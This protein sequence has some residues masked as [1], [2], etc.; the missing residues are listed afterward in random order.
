M[1]D[2]DE[3]AGQE[4]VK[5]VGTFGDEALFA[6]SDSD[7]GMPEVIQA[8]VDQATAHQSQLDAAGIGG[9]FALLAE[10]LRD[11][12]AQVIT[13]DHSG[14][15]FGVNAQI[16]SMLLT[17]GGAIVNTGSIFRVVGM[18]TAAA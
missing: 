4:T 12:W 6:P 5:Q 16:L 10:Y 18:A 11:P 2:I 9:A 13:F 8:F 14:V 17:G 1:S 3:H 7:V 15:F